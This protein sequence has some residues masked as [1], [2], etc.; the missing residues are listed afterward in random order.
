MCVGG[1]LTLVTCCEASPPPGSFYNQCISQLTKSQGSHG[2]VRD[3]LGVPAHSGS[4]KAP[5]PFHSKAPEQILEPARHL[6]V[7]LNPADPPQSLRVAILAPPSLPHVHK[8]ECPS[9]SL[10][11]GRPQEEPGAV[12]CVWCPLLCQVSGNDLP[13]LSPVSP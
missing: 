1:D 3:K 2:K 4:I 5:P 12:V 10:P 7:S 8:A 13:D 11:R 6:V 9:H